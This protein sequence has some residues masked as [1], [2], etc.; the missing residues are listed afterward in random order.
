MMI[1]M[2]ESYSKHDL[3]VSFGPIFQTERNSEHGVILEELC[4]EGVPP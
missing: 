1:E 3:T 2:A 4:G